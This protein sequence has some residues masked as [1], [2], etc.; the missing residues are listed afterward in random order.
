M[1]ISFINIQGLGNPA[2]IK[3]VTFLAEGFDLDVICLAEIKSPKPILFNNY[4]FFRNFRANSSSGGSGVLVSKKLEVI[5]NDSFCSDH[6]EIY[7]VDIKYLNT[8]VRVV[9]CYFTPGKVMNDE[10]F[11]KFYIKDKTILCGDFNAKHSELFNDPSTV[12]GT[13]K[14]AGEAL[15]E[16]VAKSDLELLS[17]GEPTHTHV[18]GSQDQL[19]IFFCSEK[20]KSKISSDVEV[21]PDLTGSDHFPITINLDIQTSEPAY[22]ALRL[23]FRK[24]KWDTFSKT[25]DSEMKPLQ[26][27]I[28]D[29]KFNDV[30][31]EIDFL[32]T[33]LTDA[34][35]VGEKAAIPR[36]NARKI[37]K[38]PIDNE[39]KAAILHRRKMRRIW[40]NSQDRID[41]TNYNR[42]TRV[43][44]NLS[45]RANTV[46]DNKDCSKM[47]SDFYRGPR[48]FWIKVRSIFENRKAVSAQASYPLKDSDGFPI[49]DNQEKSNIFAQHLKS[50]FKVPTG[51]HFSYSFRKNMLKIVDQYKDLMSPNGDRDRPV[52]QMCVVT[53]DDVQTTIDNLFNKAPGDDGI[54]NVLL[55]HSPASFVLLLTYLFNLILKHGYIPLIWKFALVILIPKPG[56]DPTTPAGFRPISLLSCI[57]KVLERIMAK[58]FLC[59]M[60][61]L[62][63]I[64]PFQCAFQSRKSIDDHLFRLGQHV[65][66]AKKNGEETIIVC[67]DNHAAFDICDPDAIRFRMIN[68]GLPKDFIRYMSNFLSGRTFRVRVRD[69]FSAVMEADAGSPQGSSVSP[70]TYLLLTSNIFTRGR[71]R[72]EVFIG[73]FADDIALWTSDRFRRNAVARMN[74]ALDQVGDWMSRYRQILNPTK[75]QAMI[76][77]T[78]GPPKAG[79]TPVF[80]KGVALE[81]KEW[82]LYLGVRF[83]RTL[84]WKPQ[85]E[86]M[87]SRFNERMCVLRK[88]CSRNSGI[89]SKVALVVYK[90]FVRPVC[91]V[92][93]PGFLAM[94]KYQLDRLQVLQNKALRLCL[95]ADYDTKLEVLHSD[96]KIDFISDHL[97][98]KT[99]NFVVKA[100]ENFSITGE[101]ARFYLENF[102]PSELENT[103]LGII[104]SQLGNQNF[105][106]PSNDV[107]IEEIV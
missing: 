88:L 7:W 36:E 46:Q 3:S 38:T 68:T 77:T 23:N 6:I 25:V 43:V 30:F 39:L 55:R 15:I 34:L 41:K 82:V 103:P 52:D 11:R 28:D 100:L 19:D 59:K 27:R 60:Q 97:K 2:K 84:S 66:L 1:R 10:I 67:L 24:A 17:R 98:R 51:E 74:E 57:V 71:G 63:I 53:T 80:V 83:D 81:W 21:L 99:V 106:R 90:A 47:N 69:A 42:A 70:P 85:Y 37:Y 96:A 40:V 94:K 14:I 95:R 93:C 33:G 89:S 44:Q 13:A 107:V 4:Q 26:V 32:A 16:V 58:R 75:S 8:F 72:I 104:Y 105:F 65:A 35:H 12:T 54:S 49:T 31:E 5:N 86:H 101:E 78:K 22:P 29:G 61:E 9:S 91:E 79:S 62:N 73:H 50:T 20:L 56:K 102:T 18:D 48:L 64:P 76:F 87:I 45:K 92:G